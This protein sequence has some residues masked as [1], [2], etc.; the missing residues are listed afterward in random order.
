MFSSKFFHIF[1]FI[2]FISILFPSESF[3]KPP[4]LPGKVSG[5]VF[6]LEENK[7]V[8]LKSA[9]L[10]LLDAKDSTVVTG[11]KSDN[12]GKFTIKTNFG[13]YILKVTFVGYETLFI[14]NIVLKKGIE[15]ITLSQ[16]VL[17][18]NTLKT[19]EVTVTA[20]RPDV[21]VGIDKY[22]FNIKKGLVKKDGDAKDV[23]RNLPSVR[24]DMEGVK[25]L[26]KKPVN[27]MLVLLGEEIGN[28]Y[29]CGMFNLNK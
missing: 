28:V 2:L 8:A 22:T 13:E 24:V 27:I 1:V 21:V 20:E 6:S 29:F 18:S 19:D 12:L 5:Q 3:A 16:I 7:K 14:P 25:M 4:V 23:L 17:K 11:A 26:G 15:S 10:S 9:S